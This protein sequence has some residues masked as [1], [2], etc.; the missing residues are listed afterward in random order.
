[1]LRLSVRVPAACA[2][3]A[4]ARLAER[5]PAGWEERDEGDELELAVY[6]GSEDE[7]GLARLFPSVA[8]A[9]VEDGWAERWREFHRPVRIGPLWV[10]PPWEPVP[11]DALAVVIDPG[12]AFGTGS[13]PT[14]RLCLSLLLEQ[15]RAGVVDLG[16]GSG[17]LSIAAARLGFDPVEGVDRDPAAV[18]ACLANAAANDVFVGARMLDL[19]MDDPPRAPLVLANLDL[20]LLDAIVPRVR[21]N[22]LIA[23]GYLERDR[24]VLPGWQRLDRRIAHGWA[25]ELF[26]ARGG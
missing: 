3:D 12:R 26:A 16:C 18:E 9:A 22:R 4:R 17:V 15:P 11:G 10:G 24:L 1:M 2:E 23:S 8:R 25:A 7:A 5:F 19:L 21:A 20:G 6:G 13:H 14:T